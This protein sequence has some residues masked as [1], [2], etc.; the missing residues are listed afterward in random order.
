MNREQLMKQRRELMAKM[1]EMNA[2]SAA[3]TAE[4]QTAW[5]ELKSQVRAI[6]DQLARMDEL[7]AMGQSGGQPEA[8]QRSD[9][10]QSGTTPTPPAANGQ[11][12][13]D[14]P[15]ERLRCA[16]IV[17]LC[18]QFGMDSRQ[19][20]D[21]G[22]SVDE[23]RKA[24]LGELGKRNA[25]IPGA[26][27]AQVGVENVDKFREQASDA[28]IM[29][30]GLDITRATRER[31]T[32]Y[33]P[34]DGARELMH[35][36]LH[37][38]MRE[39]CALR[40]KQNVNR[41]S[42]DDLRR[43]VFTP[44]SQFSA[45][46]DNTVNKSMLIGYTDAGVTF[47]IWTRPGSNP[48]FKP[49]R[50]YRLSEAGTPQKILQNGEFHHDQMS[51]QR[52]QLQLET[53]GIMFTLS[54]QAIINDDLSY[55]TKMPAAYVRGFRRLINRN[56]YGILNN[57]TAYQVDNV[58]LFASG[59]GNLAATPAY[60]S[61]AAMGKARAAMRKQKNVRADEFLNVAPA[62]A[63]AGADL[64]TD[65]EILL[66]SI[67]DPD[68]QNANV[69]NPFRNKMQLVTDAEITSNTSTNPDWFLAADPLAVDTIE[70]AYLNGN[71]MPTLESQMS[72]EQLG[73]A[74]RVYGDWDIDI[75]DYRGLYKV[76]GAA[77]A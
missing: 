47:D 5:D 16:E 58:A 61:R 9:T 7:E 19:Y 73:M 24:V 30:A 46:L 77:A 36:G 27:R 69:L 55:L 54:R 8:G 29:R 76:P 49:T 11:R 21:Q 67:A 44:D 57:N 10:T 32:A 60:P 64:E 48:D 43:E 37:A 53:F 75:L 17:S 18:A 52:V 71:S 20:I 45:M 15:A 33:K 68:S 34:V 65:L 50:R 41:M 2:R 4:D 63:L 13:D 3:F 74:W 1:H 28:I 56:V 42:I 66:I 22:T 35:M 72:F 70:V 25:P 12:A 26:P 14:T 23:V 39:Y 59:H 62:F 51:D 40:G 38:M 6:D 31:G